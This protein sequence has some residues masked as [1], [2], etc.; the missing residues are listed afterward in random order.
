[1]FKKGF[2]GNANNE[3]VIVLLHRE[4]VDSI[5]G[6]EKTLHWI[7]GRVRH[8]IYPPLCLLGSCCV[9]LQ[10][11]ILAIELYHSKNPLYVQ[12]G[13]IICTVDIVDIISP[14]P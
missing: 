4:L 14:T 12:Y 6:L 3:F 7:L 13:L 1:M 8:S 10:S 9:L 5:H 2:E 11:E